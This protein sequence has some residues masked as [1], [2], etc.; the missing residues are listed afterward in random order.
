MNT[1]EEGETQ[2]DAEMMEESDSEEDVNLL[3]I[4]TVFSGLVFVLL[5]N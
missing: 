5:F 1:L 2:E 3:N 4:L